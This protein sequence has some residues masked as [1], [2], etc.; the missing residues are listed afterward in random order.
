MILQIRH[1]AFVAATVW[2]AA[3]GA[4]VIACETHETAEGA[5]AARV[6][7]AATGPKV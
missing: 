1:L 4:G 2:G 7:S 6:V 3:Q 5:P